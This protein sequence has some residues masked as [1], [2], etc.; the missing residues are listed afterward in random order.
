ML[1][2]QLTTLIKTIINRF[3]LIIFPFVFFIQC[4]DDQKPDENS[5]PNILFIMGDDH[6]TQAISCYEGLFANYAK[7]V[8][9]DRLATEGILFRN[10]F[11]TNA[12]CSPARATL[13][14]GKYSHK[15]GVRCLRQRFDTTQVS[16]PVLMQ[17]A[18]YQTAVF[19]KW[20]LKSTP[21]GFDD[22]KVLEVQGRYQDPEFKEMGKEKLKTRKG[23][24]TDIITDLTLDF[25]DNRKT[26]KP[27]MVLCHYKATHDPWASRAPYDTLWENEDIIYPDN[28]LDDYQN[29]S[30]AANRTTLK[31]EYMNQGTFPHDRLK[32]ATLM[33]QRAHIYQQYIKSFLRCGRVLD[34]NVGR[35]IQYLIDNDLYDNTI[36]IYT[37]DQGH[38]LGEHGFFSKRFMYEEALRIPLIIRYP[39]WIDPGQKNDDMIANVDIAPTI[40]E[41]AG[42]IPTDDIQG[43]SFLDNMKGQTPSDW[44]EAIYYHYWQHLLHRDVA[45]HFG[46]RTKNHKLIFYYGLPLGQTEYPP[47]VPEWEMFD[48][49]KDP[50]EMYN[51]YNHDEYLEIQDQ[52]K[53][54]LHELQDKYDD[55]G[56]EYPEL[57]QIINEYWK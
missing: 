55:R 37:A 15:N 10:A 29:R 8:N 49:S 44:P 17:N 33:E 38:F 12:I 16:I 18:G 27:F 32:N 56:M 6:T 5:R 34:E 14:T 22:Y 54:K 19:G 40:L 31:L 2:I 9:I 25:L 23:W 13:L 57:Q 39:E 4:S 35:I 50:G 26:D 30:E 21:T 45:A 36:I 3:P 52:L 42:L 7:T 51:V 48:L 1:N 53:N 43:R 46:I 20:H 41:M 24:S 47:T 11:C 28:F